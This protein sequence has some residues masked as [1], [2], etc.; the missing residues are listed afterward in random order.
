MSRRPAANESG[1]NW[2]F[3]RAERED[4]K[5][6][7]RIR[8]ALAAGE[9]HGAV[10]LTRARL[11]SRSLRLVA[12]REMNSRLRASRQMTST[13]LLATACRVDAFRPS[14]EIVRA[15]AVPQ[16]R[17][18]WRTT[19][20]FG[21]MDRIAQT[22]VRL[23]LQPFAALAIQGYQFAALPGD[24]R[25]GRAAI[26]AV[27]EAIEDGYVW[28]SEID[29][30][31]CFGSFF[32]ELVV[33]LLPIPK[34]VGEAHVAPLFLRVVGDGVVGSPS[35]DGR[36]TRRASLHGLPQ[37]GLASSIVA[38]MLIGLMLAEL[39]SSSSVEGIKLLVWSDNILVMGKS[40]LQTQIALR[41]LRSALSRHS[42]GSFATTATEV[43]HVDHG[44]E[45]IGRRF[46]RKTDGRVLVHP[47]GKKMRRFT[48][49]V[50]LGFEDIYYF[51][52]AR[53]YF[54][55]FLAGWRAH[56]RVGWPE[57]DSW[58]KKVIE[59]Y[60]RRYGYQVMWGNRG[61]FVRLLSGRPCDGIYP[62]SS[63]FD[64]EILQYW[65]E[66]VRHWRDIVG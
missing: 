26:E 47:V 11:H 35:S 66:G 1:P 45:W 58:T 41:S 5:M 4:A 59:A 39:S 16:N 48:T 51:E 15:I 32:R 9:L 31:D 54:R 52:V 60:A 3:R 46:Q 29:I 30:C 57:C 2:Y 25:D 27:R 50:F 63:G 43:R 18:R 6:E 61:E 38:A 12:A 13:D 65:K 64:H 14:G 33:R 21:V 40:Q 49:T 17:G 34:A 23:A 42:T 37:G 62:Q 22:M 44:F 55:N 7:R 53:R 24:R 19:Y 10:T 56:Y 20:N 36:T 8:R 28:V